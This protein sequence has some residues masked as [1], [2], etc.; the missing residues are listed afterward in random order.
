M[1]AGIAHFRS[2]IIHKQQDMS[3][4]RNISLNKKSSLKLSSG[5]RVCRGNVGGFLRELAFF[6]FPLVSNRG[7]IW[8]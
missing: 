8:L 2:T 4:S 1:G 6:D 3:E 5:L 7:Q